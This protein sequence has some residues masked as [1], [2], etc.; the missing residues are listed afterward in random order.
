MKKA[1]CLAVILLLAG[2]VA[3]A[4]AGLKVDRQKNDVVVTE[5]TVYGNPEEAA[6]AQVRITSQWE[7]HLIWDTVY[8]VGSGVAESSFRFSSMGETWRSPGTYSVDINFYM[9]W[10]SAITNGPIIQFDADGYPLSRVLRSVMERTAPGERRTETVCLK[11]FYDYYPLNVSFNNQALDVYYSEDYLDVYYSE[12]YS[13]DVSLTEFLRIP[14]GEAAVE[15]TMEKNQDGEVV[16]VKCSSLNE[17]LFA[18]CAAFGRDGCYLAYYVDDWKNGKVGDPGEDYG[19]YYFPYVEKKENRSDLTIDPNQARLIY[20]LQPGIYTVEMEL[21]EAQGE[22]YLVTKEEQEFYLSV[23]DT[24]GDDL[25]LKQKLMLRSVAGEPGEKDNPYWAQLSVQDNGVLMI[26]RDGSFV[27]AARLGKEFINWGL[28]YHPSALNTNTI[29]KDFET[30]I[31]REMALR[32]GETPVSQENLTFP[33]ENVWAFDGQRLAIASFVDWRSLSVDLTVYTEEG[34]AWYGICEHSGDV[35]KQQ[36]SS[37]L[38][39]TP[40]G[41]FKAYSDII[42]DRMH[43]TGVDVNELLGIK[44]GL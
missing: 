9:N 20:R 16:D 31:Q 19:I 2:P 6:G 41:T 33:V 24:Q 17:P 3:F 10:G 15:I 35:F 4:A 11:D 44:F 42:I 14:I 7:G 26:W 8:T 28:E 5:T 21:N 1:F 36:S 12:D 40:P 39:L 18:N 23:F 38:R 29:V 27:F 37:L 32:E 25:S 22:L 43:G 30:E 34:L 13:E